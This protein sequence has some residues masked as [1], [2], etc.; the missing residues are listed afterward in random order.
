MGKSLGYGLGLLG[1]V[2]R[3]RG[4]VEQNF[5]VNKWIKE[6]SKKQVDREG[7]NRENEFVDGGISGGG[8][9]GLGIKF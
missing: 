2:F 6:E 9:I 5:E 4:G 7:V 1:Q 8:C 3:L